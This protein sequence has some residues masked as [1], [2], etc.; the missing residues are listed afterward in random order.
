MTGGFVHPE[1]KRLKKKLLQS[2]KNGD[3]PPLFGKRFFNVHL[4]QEPKGKRRPI[5]GR[6]TTN[7]WG[8]ILKGEGAHCV[9]GQRPSAGKK[10]TVISF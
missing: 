7:P 3:D 2:P 8:V 4:S 5:P 10:K 6:E 1:G 9:K